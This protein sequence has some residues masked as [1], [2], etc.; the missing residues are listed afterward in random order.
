MGIIRSL[1]MVIA[2]AHG[3]ADVIEQLRDLV[4]KVG[5][6]EDKLIAIEVRLAELACRRD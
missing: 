2:S 3:I 4:I 6:L 1:A 5:V